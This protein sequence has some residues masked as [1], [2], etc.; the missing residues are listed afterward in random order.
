MAGGGH[1]VAESPARAWVGLELVAAIGRRR[2]TAPLWHGRRGWALHSQ[3]GGAP[4]GL[5]HSAPEFPLTDGGA[6]DR[7]SPRQP[8]GRP[9]S[10]PALGLSA[11]VRRTCAARRQSSCLAG[12][13]NRPSS[14]RVCC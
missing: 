13:R 10:C 6:G 3:L 5:A 2:L 9:E 7:G 8:A 12:E 4:I 11:A 14:G 1:V